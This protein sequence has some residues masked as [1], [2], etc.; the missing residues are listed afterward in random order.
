MSSATHR[1]G[2]IAIEVLFITAI[3]LTGIAIIVP[4]YLNEN[5]ATSVLV[6]VKSSASDA[7]SYINSGVTVEREPYTLLNLVVK[8]SNYTSPDFNV[9]SVTENENGNKIT[10]NVEIGYSGKVDLNNDSI[11]RA[12]K[13]FIVND[14]V[15]HTDVNLKGNTMYYNDKLLSINIHVVKL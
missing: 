7:C 9:L 15:T 14:L 5:S 13:E 8:K 2:Q 1:K 12:L 4:P 11:A 6:Y 3:I 10:V